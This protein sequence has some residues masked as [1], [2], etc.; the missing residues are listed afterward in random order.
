LSENDQLN[1]EISNK[2]NTIRNLES[3]NNSY[4][5]ENSNL[6]VKNQSLSLDIEMYKIYKPQ[7]YKIVS[8]AHYYY[9]YRCDE[10]YNQTQCYTSSG[11]YVSVYAIENGYGLTKNGWVKMSDLKIR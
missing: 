2:D 1:S 11:N 7:S 4:K 6:K 5:K 9:K 8:D 10:S 3:Q